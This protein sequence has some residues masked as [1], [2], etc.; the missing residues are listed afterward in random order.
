MQFFDAPDFDAHEQV[1]FAY[2]T[3]TGLKAI[4]AIHD[5]TLGPAMGGC[6]I[7]PYTDDAAA[8]TDVLRLSRGM[9]YKSA[10]AG[11]PLGGGKCVVIGDSH[12]IKTPELLHALGCAIDRLG[13]R[14]ITAEDVGTDPEDMAHIARATQF[15]VGIDQGD[16]SGDP[17][18]WTAR[19]V[20]HGIRA[21][22]KYRL[23]ADS[24]NNIHIVV[25]GLGHVGEAVCDAL[26]A[27]GARLTVSD[28]DA[29][30]CEEIAARTG[31]NI[32]APEA[33]YDVA[34]DVFAPCALGA[35]INPETL[36][37]LQVA[38]IAG[39]ANNQLATDDLA[40]TLRARRILYAPDYAINAGGIIRVAHEY[41]DLHDQTQQR[42]AQIYDTLM[43][44]FV[45]ADGEGISTLEAADRR[46]V[47][48]L[49]S[50]QESLEAAA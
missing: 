31:A 34:A 23:G 27:A 25:Q 6:R 46:A 48:R 22:V 49:T 37:R 24:L 18:P 1:D 29:M 36:P 15:V 12:H 47:R 30:R 35:I 9:T 3:A 16:A 8:L 20:V 21:A 19:G 2:D 42:V 4:I 10:L 14:Y 11:L 43:E 33:I 41:L 40:A 39:S 45:L 28:I 7:F 38:V 32:V 17:S 13:G 5:T 44:L 50:G 26:H